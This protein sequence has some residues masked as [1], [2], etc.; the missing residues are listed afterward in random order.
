MGGANG[1]RECAP[2]DKLRDTHHVLNGDGFREG[3]NPS[4]TSNDFARTGKSLI[5]YPAP[6]AKIFRFALYPNQIYIDCRPVP[7]EGRFAIVTDV[8]CGMRWTW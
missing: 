3:L 5:F 4:H 1:S 6:F 2:D 8:G 7:N